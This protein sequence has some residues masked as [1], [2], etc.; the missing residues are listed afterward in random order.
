MCIYMYIYNMYIYI[1]DMYVYIYIYLLYRYNN[2][3]KNKKYPKYSKMTSPSLI[4]SWDLQ[5]LAIPTGSVPSAS[6]SP[7]L[8]MGAVITQKLTGA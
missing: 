7:N 1:L 4:H 2:T 6:R 8:V 3:S 5:A